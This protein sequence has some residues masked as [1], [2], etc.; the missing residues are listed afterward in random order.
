MYGHKGQ[1]MRL[2]TDKLKWRLNVLELRR[3]T[4]ASA[5]RHLLPHLELLVYRVPLSPQRSTLLRP[6]AATIIAQ[7][8]DFI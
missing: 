2:S 3:C 8:T 7:C 6:L 5:S 4:A 1:K